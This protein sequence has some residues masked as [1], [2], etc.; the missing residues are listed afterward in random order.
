[1][2]FSVK[3]FWKMRALCGQAFPCMKVTPK[4]NHF[5]QEYVVSVTLSVQYSINKEQVWPPSITYSLP[6]Q[7]TTNPMSDTLYDTWI[8]ET[9]ATVTLHPLSVVVLE[10][11]ETWLVT[12]DDMSPVCISP[13]SVWIMVT[14]LNLVSPSTSFS[15]KP[16]FVR[17]KRMPSSHSRIRTLL[18]LATLW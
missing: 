1:M 16:T 14:H 17:Y 6:H 2:L 3:L 4:S 13:V 12:E 11:S 15:T 7:N 5:L 10:R 8:S 18:E 9:F